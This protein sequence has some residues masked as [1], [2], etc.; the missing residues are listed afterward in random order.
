MLTFHLDLNEPNFIANPYP[1]LTELREQAPL[2]YD[3][4]WHKVF[5]TRYD[6]IA[7]LLRDRRLGRSIPQGMSREELGLSP[8]NPAQAPFDQFQDNRLMDKE[9]PDHTR[10]RA[11]VAKAFT[12]Q[13]VENLRGKIQE[14]ANRLLDAAEVRGEIEIVRD[15]AEPLPVIVIA[16]LL[17]IPE[18][19]RHQLRPWSKA[20][21]K[22]R[23]FAQ[24]G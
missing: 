5:V 17:G 23:T 22:F 15:L 3:E 20:I 6:D 21:V 13:R 18:Q 14:Q 9:P 4:G 24:A 2:F 12:P 1:Q 10:L 8:P 16:E 19:D 7:A 11:L